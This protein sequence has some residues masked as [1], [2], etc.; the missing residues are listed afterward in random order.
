MDPQQVLT[1]AQEALSVRRVFGDPIQA[2]GITIIPVAKVRGGGGGGGRA[3]EQGGVGYGLSARPAGVYVVR[4]GDARW[5]PAIDVNRVILGGQL[6]AITAIVT[7]G[8]ILRRWLSHRP[9]T[10]SLS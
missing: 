2:D 10:P 1:G 3:S 5:R 6:V 8:P 7:F 9:T 4:N